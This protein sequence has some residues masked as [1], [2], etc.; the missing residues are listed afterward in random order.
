M[1]C[2][3]CLVKQYQQSS[4]NLHAL[5]KEN[6]I[7]KLKVSRLS[8]KEFLKSSTLEMDLTKAKVQISRLTLQTKQ[9]CLNLLYT[10][11]FSVSHLMMIYL[12]KKRE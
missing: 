7:L 11:F 5:R 3:V 2:F 8:H 1:L 6:I 12:V 9:V 10:D 4:S